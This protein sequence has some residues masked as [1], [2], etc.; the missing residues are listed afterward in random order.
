MPREVQL[1]AI[2]KGIITYLS[3]CGENGGAICS[4]TKAPE[5]RGLDLEQVERSLAGLIKRN[6]IYR[7]GIRYKIVKGT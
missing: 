2:Q 6:I 3:R 5:F 1:G 4:T 7:D